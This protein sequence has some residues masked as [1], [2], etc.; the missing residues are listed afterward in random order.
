MWG[1][2]CGDSRPGCPRS[3]A[4]QACYWMEGV[5]LSAAVL[6]AE[7]RISRGLK[8]QRYLHFLFLKQIVKRRARILRPQT[9]RCR[10]LL[11][12]GHANLIQLTLIPRILL[13]DPLLHRLHALEPAPGIEIRAL[14]AR[15][16]L[17][18]ALRA[19]PARRHSLQHGAA[20]RASRNRMRAREI[21]RL[22]PKSIVVLRWRR[23]APR[24]LSRSL[25]RLVVAILITMLPVFC[26][27]T[28]SQA[29]AYCLPNVAPAASA[30]CPTHARPWKRGHDRGREGTTV[31]ERPRPWKS[32]PS[33]AA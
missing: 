27:H 22:R 19:L 29:R 32:G 14:L 7:R 17:K 20:L 30:R 24:L 8:R 26:C 18:P 16:Q 21:D 23:R 9:R 11:L 15:M 33:R 1:W 25:P 31:E 13:R 2:V 4:P 3:G 28:P 6:Q 12:P 10:S 5:I